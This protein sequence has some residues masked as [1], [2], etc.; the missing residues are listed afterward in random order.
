MNQ[1]AEKYDRNMRP[2]G[3]GGAVLRWHD[4]TRAP[5]ALEGFPFFEADRVYR[6]L[7]VKP[8]APLPEAVDRL[9]EDTAGGQVRFRSDSGRVAVNP[10]AL[11]PGVVRDMGYPVQWSEPGSMLEDARDL[12]VEEVEVT[13]DGTGSLKAALFDESEMLAVQAG[14]QEEA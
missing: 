4:V 10:W 6:R 3:T 11:R 1:N 9:A 8:P 5:F 13:A 12:Y 2:M 7:P 14:F